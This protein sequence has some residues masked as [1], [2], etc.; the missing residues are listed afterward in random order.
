MSARNLRP[1]A[2][3]SGTHVIMICCEGN[4]KAAWVSGSQPDREFRCLDGLRLGGLKT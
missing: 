1:N 3:A 4:L 2:L